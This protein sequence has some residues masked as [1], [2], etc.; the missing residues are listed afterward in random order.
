MAVSRLSGTG[1]AMAQTIRVTVLAAA[2]MLCATATAQAQISQLVSPGPLSKAHASLEGVD[3][4]QKCHEPGRNVTNDRCLS[5]HKPIADRIRL[6][7]G[8]HRDAT[9]DCAAC[10]VEHAGVDAELRHVD[11]KAF[12]HGTETGFVFDGRHVAIAK[13]CAKCHKTRSFLTLSP[14]CSTCHTDVHK[15]SLGSDCRACHTTAVPF[16]DARSQFDHSKEWTSARSATSP[17]AM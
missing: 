5:C 16:K 14:T 6:K 10:H 9:G 8:V 1:R 2:A 17:A 3:K 11:P 12:N 7:K 4:C 15:P 13:D